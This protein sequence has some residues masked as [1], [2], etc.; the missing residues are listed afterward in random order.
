[1]VGRVV[2][3][4]K[5]EE[6]VE[7]KGEE[8]DHWSQSYQLTPTGLTYSTLLTTGATLQCGSSI[9]PLFPQRGTWYYNTKQTFP[10]YLILLVLVMISKTT[11]SRDT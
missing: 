8:K 7:E 5:V 10:I 1:M 2:R 6:E 4:A 3:N 9:W 11:F